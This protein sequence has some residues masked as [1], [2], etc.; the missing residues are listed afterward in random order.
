[1][2]KTILFLKK[3]MPVLFRLSILGVISV[4]VTLYFTSCTS[5][6]KAEKFDY[7]GSVG[8][9]HSLIVSPDTLHSNY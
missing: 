2:K 6:L 9:N 7:R 4:S 3:L 5:M 1:M 8:K